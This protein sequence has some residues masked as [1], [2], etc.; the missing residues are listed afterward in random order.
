MSI[1][2]KWK[3]MKQILERLVATIR[4]LEVMMHNKKAKIGD[5]IKTNQDY[6]K[7]EMKA[8]VGSLASRIDSNQGKMDTNLKEVIA[9]MRAWRKEMTACQETMEA[10]LESKE[11]TSVEIESVAVHEEVPKEEAVVEILEH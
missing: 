8:Q 7:E 6:M 9:E 10:C 4:W 5:E 3:K 1:L 11:P 2:Q